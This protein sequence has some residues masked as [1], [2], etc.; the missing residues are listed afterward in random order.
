MIDKIE[1]LSANDDDDEEEEDDDDLEVN[2][3]D[4]LR[5]ENSFALMLDELQMRLF[6]DWTFEISK[7]CK[8]TGSILNQNRHV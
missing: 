6:P 5:N 4:T 3:V 8:Y 7:N 2:D 1:C